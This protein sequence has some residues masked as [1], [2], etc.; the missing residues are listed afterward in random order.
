MNGDMKSLISFCPLTLSIPRPSFHFALSNS[1]QVSAFRPFNGH[2][3]TVAGFHRHTD[4]GKIGG[5]G[6]ERKIHGARKREVRGKGDKR[7]V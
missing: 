2:E 1:A 7:H 6:G 3:E 4:A 5:D